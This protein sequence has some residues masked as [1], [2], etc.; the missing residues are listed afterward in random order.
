[1]P[2]GRVR[3]PCLLHY[4]SVILNLIQNLIFICH[5]CGGRNPFISPP[6]IHQEFFS[7]CEGAPSATAAIS[8]APHI[9]PSKIISPGTTIYGIWKEPIQQ[10]HP[11]RRTVSGSQPQAFE[12]AASLP[13]QHDALQVVSG[14]YGAMPKTTLRVQATPAG[15]RSSGASLLP[16]A[17]LMVILATS[18][19]RRK[20]HYVC[21]ACGKPK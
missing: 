9:G 6:A 21:H 15:I 8:Q 4:S 16:P 14:N 10:K 19:L 20:T 12:V 7:H 18:E 11:A 5:S 3:R 17:A 2:S 1:M 13:L